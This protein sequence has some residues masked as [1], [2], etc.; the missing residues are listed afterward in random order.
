MWGRREQRVIEEVFPIA[1]EFAPGDDLR[2]QSVLEAAMANDD[3]TVTNRRRR[4][5]PALDRRYTEASQ[6][7][8]EF[9]TRHLIVSKGVTGNHRSVMGGEPDRFGF[10]NEI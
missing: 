9:E 5:R 6:W 1:G 8:D 7:K 3:H 2:I 10:R 4:C